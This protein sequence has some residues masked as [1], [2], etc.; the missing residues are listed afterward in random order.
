MTST[1][2]E[3]EPPARTRLV[4]CVNGDG[5]RTM[6]ASGLC[7]WCRGLTEGQALAENGTEPRCSLHYTEDG[8]MQY[9][10]DQ[11]DPPCTVCPPEELG[12][13]DLTAEEIVRIARRE[14]AEAY[15]RDILTRRGLPTTYEPDEGVTVHPAA[16][17][18]LLTSYERAHLGMLPVWTFEGDELHRLL[19]D[20][21]RRPGPGAIY[22]VRFSV[23]EG[24]LKWKINEGMWSAGAD[25]EVRP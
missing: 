20:L 4:E 10:C 7:R 2:S 11:G 1:A 12:G 16:L 6:H 13:R 25:P 14:D 22:R 15:A 9:R 21:E 18:A 8:P 24:E 3:Q 17:E 19:D 5:R 23:D